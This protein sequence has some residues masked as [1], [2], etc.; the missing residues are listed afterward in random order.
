MICLTFDTEGCA[1]AFVED[2]LKLADP[3]PG[4]LTF[5]CKERYALLGG[6]GVRWEV[7][8]QPALRPGEEAEAALATLAAA[9]P[10][11]KGLRP[12][13]G[14]T[15]HPLLEAAARRGLRY[16]SI[17]APLYQGGLAPYAL[18]WG[19]WELPI[20]YQDTL[21]LVRP[22]FWPGSQAFATEILHR[23]ARH[24]GLYVFAFHPVH[25]TLNT[26]TQAYWETHRQHVQ[27]RAAVRARAYPGR[28][29]RTF[30]LDLID[31][32]AQTPTSSFSMTEALDH[33][34]ARHVTGLWEG[35]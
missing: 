32:L 27:D 24:P 8:L 15:S 1:E 13:A 14:C 18:P 29:V 7:G 30:F 22:D 19:G 6:H 10:E 5:F 28:G 17:T 25:L 9:I 2:A 26:P 16:T 3:I 35:R 34:A 11:A 4:K 20:Y 31:V 23:A 33:Y 12:Q 21:D